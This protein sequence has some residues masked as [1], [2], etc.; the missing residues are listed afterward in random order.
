V[1]GAIGSTL[2]IGSTPKRSLLRCPTDLELVAKIKD[3]VG[4]YLNPPERAIVL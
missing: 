4:L 2:Q 3:V 1:D